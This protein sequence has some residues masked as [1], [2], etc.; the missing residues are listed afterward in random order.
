MIVSKLNYSIEHFKN[1]P[2]VIHPDN[3]GRPVD[4]THF[5]G[6]HLDLERNNHL[7]ETLKQVKLEGEMLEFGVYK[8]NTINI[9]ADIFK[10]RTIHGF[11]SFEG[12]PEDW[13]TLLG[14][15]NNPE[16]IKRKK[17]YFALDELPEVRSNVRLWKG[18]FDDTTP[19]YIEELKPKQIAFLHVDGDLYS[20][21]KS[22]LYMLEKYI[23]KDTIICFDE[24]YPFGRKKYDTWEEG[25]FKALKEWTNDFDREFEVISHNLHQ[26]CSIRIV[27]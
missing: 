1:G 14:E 3:R 6:K 4:I 10:D 8:G 12:L 11:D 24:F 15:V 25:E 22:N 5:K 19:K 9:T 17:G 7:K 26:Q 16:R 2:L 20:S 23:V 27:K 13:A 18:W 21:A